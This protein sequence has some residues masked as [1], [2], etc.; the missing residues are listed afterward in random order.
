M[1]LKLE[2]GQ[3]NEKSFSIDSNLYL[4]RRFYA[5]LFAL[6]AHKGRCKGV[7]LICDLAL[8]EK[9]VRFGGIRDG[10]KRVDKVISYT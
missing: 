2:N 5:P 10:V 7:A 4:I 6:L 3:R 9:L 1:G 8:I